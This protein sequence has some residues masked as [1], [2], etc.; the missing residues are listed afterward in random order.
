MSSNN[1]SSGIGFPGLLTVLF[2]GLKLTGHITWS[3]WWVLSPLI[4]SASIALIVILAIIISA[5]IVDMKK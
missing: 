3:W 1:S 4:I 2:I 5:I